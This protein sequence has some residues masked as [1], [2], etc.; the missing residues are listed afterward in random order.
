MMACAHHINDPL[1]FTNHVMA[2]WLFR[3]LVKTSYKV[4]YT[5]S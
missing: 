5:G 1:G 4:Y 2:I 3:H